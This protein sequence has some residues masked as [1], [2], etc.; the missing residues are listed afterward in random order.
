MQ[1]GLP[2]EWKNFSSAKLRYPYG[3]V[4]ISV[5]PKTFVMTDKTSTDS[6][7]FW[8]KCVEELIPV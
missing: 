5:R 6:A 3:L 8:M 1:A 4:Y 7:G 2:T